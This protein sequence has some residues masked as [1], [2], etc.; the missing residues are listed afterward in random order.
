MQRPATEIDLLAAI[1]KVNPG[2]ETLPGFSPTALSDKRYGLAT[3]CRNRKEALY[4]RRSKMAKILSQK[5]W[6]LLSS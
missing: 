4:G 5:R 3:D 2:D 1:F 6:Q